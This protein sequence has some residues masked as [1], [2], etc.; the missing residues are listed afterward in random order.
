MHIDRDLSRTRCLDHC[1]AD[2]GHVVHVTFGDL[3]LEND[4]SDSF[5]ANLQHELRI[6]SPGRVVHAA[7]SGDAL[8]LALRKKQKTKKCDYDLQFEEKHTYYLHRELQVIG[9]HA[10]R[11][12]PIEV[13]AE[14]FIQDPE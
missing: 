7:A 13:L 5:L 9:E 12:Q 6:V 14:V 3:L 11:V 8:P 2:A 4:G 10:A 1:E